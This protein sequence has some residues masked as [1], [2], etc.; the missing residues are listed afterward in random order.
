[1]IAAR[2]APDNLAGYN[3]LEQ[4]DGFNY[5]FEAA[6]KAV[7]FFARCLTF[8][9]GARAGEP[10]LL[11]DWQAAIVRTIFGWKRSDGNRRYRQVLIMV[12][13]K[14]GK[15]T[16]SAGLG[17]YVLFCDG[18]RGAECYCAGSDRDQA[19][20][21]HRTAAAQVRGCPGLAKRARI[22]DSQRRIVYEDS[23]WRAIPANEAG[24]H[25]FDAHLII[26]DEL[27]A[28]PGRSFFDVL[29]TSTGARVQPLEIYISTSGYDRNSVCWEQYVYA[30]Q[31]RD[32]KLV[33][34][35][36]LP[37]VYELEDSDDWQDEKAWY[38]ANPNLD[39]S[40]PLEYLQRK[41][42]KALA[43]PSFE[44]TFKRLHLNQW[45]SQEQRWLPMDKWRAS[46][47]TEGFEPEN[48]PVVGGLDLSSTT[49]VT[50]WVMLY[51]Q[52]L[53]YK[54]Q[55]HYFIPSERILQHEQRDHVPWSAWVKEGRATATP[56]NCID[57][58]VV[59]QRIIR[60]CERYKVRLVG[61]DPWNAESTRKILE[62]DHGIPC[63]KV[64]QTYSALTEP[65]KELE[66]AVMQEAL[67]IGGCPVM[68]WMAD[69]VQIKTDD[70]GNMRPV[71][72]DYHASNKKI[73]GI[74]ATL[75][76]LQ[77]LVAVPPS[78]STGTVHYV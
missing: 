14:N 15:S 36:F 29:Q 47:Q 35:A 72:P 48:M 41:H 8:V 71:K 20:L 2:A 51:K 60:D 59:H 67:D 65:C 1:M 68:D 57:Y 13:R 27:H 10:F 44:N 7:Q 18:E 64:R 42:A 58:D 73:D 54:V 22:M 37:V 63:V 32:G 62:D 66:R 52:G 21:V 16:F 3:P 50:A 77:C 23:F 43:E 45:T 19:S 61:Y 12:P 30:K 76:A 70:N 28:W 5:D 46:P 9:K 31:V 40:L 69:N 78:P 11:A 55:P 34:P 25:G 74:V 33:D 56:G 6:E 53:G 17:N 26:G 4:A 38:K 39:V 75:V 49:D 24:S